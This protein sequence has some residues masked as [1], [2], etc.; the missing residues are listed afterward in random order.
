MEL[1]YSQYYEGSGNSYN[2]GGGLITTD[3]LPKQLSDNNVHFVR[4]PIP[5]KVRIFRYAT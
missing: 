1:N 3:D 4:A 2:F 5:R